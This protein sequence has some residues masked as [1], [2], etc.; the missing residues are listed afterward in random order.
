[1]ILL[2][3]YYLVCDATAKNKE[4]QVLQILMRVS[5]DNVAVTI[6]HGS[7]PKQ[8]QLHC[9]N[10]PLPSLG[11][12]ENSQSQVMVERNVSRPWTDEEGTFK[13]FFKPFD[14]SHHLPKNQTNS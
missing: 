8:T 14:H 5:S 7:Y 9:R 4:M 1:M 6:G 2:K 3:T 11:T 13:L 10:M 12:L